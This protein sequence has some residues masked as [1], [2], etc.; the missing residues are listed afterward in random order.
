MPGESYLEEF[1][2]SPILAESVPPNSPCSLT[3]AET[4][5]NR[6]YRYDVVSSPQD[7]LSIISDTVRRISVCIDKEAKKYYIIEPLYE[8]IRN[9]RSVK[10]SAVLS[11]IG[12]VK[13]ALLLQTE[14]E[15]GI[16]VLEEDIRTY[17]ERLKNSVDRIINSTG[18]IR[19]IAPRDLN[20]LRNIVKYYV[21]RDIVGL[22]VLEPLIVDTKHIEDITIPRPGVE[23][24][25]SGKFSEVG[26]NVLLVNIKLSNI[27][28]NRLVERIVSSEGKSISLF[29]PLESLMIKRGHR[30]TVTY[31]NEVTYY[32]PSLV[33]RL[34]SE[35]WN[36]IKLF[37][38]RGLQPVIPSIL[39]PL[40]S[41]K[42]S[43]LII[44]VMGSGKT[45]ML[46]ALSYLIPLNSTIVT[47]ED[48][49]E[50][51]L[52]H[53]FWI[54]HITRPAVGAERRGEID[55]FTLVKH[56]LRESA[57]YIIIG[58]VRGEE[59]RVWAQAIATG[60]GG[61]TTFHADSVETAMAR[62]T[63]DPINI[64]PSLLYALYNIVI[65]RRKGGTRYAS[66]LYLLKS[67]SAEVSGESRILPSYYDLV[68][69]QFSE[70][71]FVAFLLGNKDNLENII[72]PET[73]VLFDKDTLYINKDLNNKSDIIKININIDISKKDSISDSY[74]KIINY[75]DKNSNIIINYL[76]KI[77]SNNSERNRLRA[78]ELLYGIEGERGISNYLRQ[79][80]TYFKYLEIFYTIAAMARESPNKLCRTLIENLGSLDIGLGGFNFTALLLLYIQDTARDQEAASRNTLD[81]I[82][83]SLFIN[84]AE[85]SK[86]SAASKYTCSE[87]IKEDLLQYLRN[88]YLS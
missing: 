73:R 56:A 85:S 41:N 49:P 66:D 57:D 39:G 25:V 4:N 61:L 18:K 72:I 46:N 15:L 70:E 21:L 59:G 75:I 24:K 34:F 13:R 8:Y 64:E 77:Y 11:L 19:S 37:A 36:L 43:T 31:G 35:P 38:Y 83:R 54:R 32:G 69:V 82:L 12:Y 60:H 67:E 65:M 84:I 9:T 20:N 76:R 42:M 45:S 51:R 17:Y 80:G 3:N 6:T 47:I 14:T 53:R 29:W 27:Q 40:I 48:T 23:V 10:Y 5:Y 81:S 78:L 50:I 79:V 22:S 87:K 30:V 62:L 7:P 28:L 63:S 74:E 86:A 58:E 1:Y 71:R 16:S 68:N 2:E 55:M 52:P 44:G 33:V 26:A 88:S